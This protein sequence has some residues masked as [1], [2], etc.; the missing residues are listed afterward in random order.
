MLSC[1]KQ[2]GVSVGNSQGQPKQQ[3]ESLF[4]A[5]ACHILADPVKGTSMRLAL[6][7]YSCRYI[8]D[9]MRRIV[10]F[11]LAIKHMTEFYFKLKEKGQATVDSLVFNQE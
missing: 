1:L 11:G 10:Q 8:I 2:E 5:G 7:T 3:Q 6:I 9:T 4:C